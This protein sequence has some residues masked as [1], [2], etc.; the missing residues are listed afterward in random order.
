MQS[1]GHSTGG[2]RQIKVGFGGIWGKQSSLD[3]TPLP[4]GPTRLGPCLIGFR[5]ERVGQFGI[6]TCPPYML[7]HASK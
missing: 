5:S 2:F 6:L 7:D 4:T 1:D 3:L